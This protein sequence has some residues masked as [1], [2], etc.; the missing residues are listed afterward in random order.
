DSTGQFSLRSARDTAVVQKM[1]VLKEKN[2]DL[3]VLLS[4]GGWG[5]CAPCSGAFST[6]EGRKRFASSVQEHLTFFTCDGIDLDWEY[7]AIPGYPGHPFSPADKDNFTALVKE[8]RSTL[9]REATITFAAGGFQRYLDEAVDWKQVMRKVNYV[10]IM[11]YDLVSGFATS[12]GHHTALFSNPQQKESTDN[13]VQF[14]LRAGV[15]PKKII[16]GA[17]FYG[18]VWEN[19]VSENNGLYQA[20]RFKMSVDYKNFAERLSPD[21]GFV[22]HWDSVTHAPYAYHPEKQWFATFDDKRSVSAK[23]EY[24][25]RNKLGG[26]MF[27]EL[28]SD[29]F[30]G[31]LLQTINDMLRK[32]V[33]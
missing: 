32:K 7:P 26:I 31:G 17:A 19:V 30:T 27:W 13:A 4:L 8:L 14:L 24:V 29:T 18:R 3:K 15:K 25:L 6:R 21:S 23:T 11:S 2:P 9:G 10:N 1:I 16:I 22:F 5:G 28:D 33:K 20:G 12:T